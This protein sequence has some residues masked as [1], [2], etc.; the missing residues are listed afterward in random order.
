MKIQTITANVYG[1][2]SVFEVVQYDHTDI[3]NVENY[4]T[5]HEGFLTASYH[6]WAFD[7]DHARKIAQDQWYQYKAQMAGIS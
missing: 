5:T 6:V 2:S 4:F 3:P 1:E 7:Y